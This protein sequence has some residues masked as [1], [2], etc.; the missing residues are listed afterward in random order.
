M[1]RNQSAAEYVGR[2]GKVDIM[3]PART[4]HFAFIAAFVEAATIRP[5]MADLKRIKENPGVFGVPPHHG[6]HG[7]A[8]VELEQLEAVSAA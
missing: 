2:K 5:F 7:E 8:D 6:P 1:Q 3:S 4:D